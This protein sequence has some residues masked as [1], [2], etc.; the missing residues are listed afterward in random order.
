MLD[1][2]P[3]ILKV[4]Y[5]IDASIDGCRVDKYSTYRS[6][7][8]LLFQRTV[9]ST[10]VASRHYRSAYRTELNTCDGTEVTYVTTVTYEGT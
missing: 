2:R 9:G 4:P 1:E 3:A 7:L 10:Y 8:E 5:E 6:S